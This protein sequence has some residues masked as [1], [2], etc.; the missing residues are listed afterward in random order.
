MA[1]QYHR[2]KSLESVPRSDDRGKT[3]AVPWDIDDDTGT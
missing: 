2:R 3:K 1:L